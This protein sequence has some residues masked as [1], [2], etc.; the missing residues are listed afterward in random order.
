MLRNTKLILSQAITRIFWECFSKRR[1]TSHRVPILV[2]HRV[3]PELLE[4]E[5]DPLYTLLPEQFEAHLAFLVREGFRTLSLREFAQLARGQS[6]PHERAVVITFDDGLADTYAIAWPL[7]QKYGIKINLFVCTGLVGEPG[8]V[9]MTQNG[10]VV[11]AGPAEQTR[12]IASHLH[13]FPHLWRALTWEELKEMNQ[14][15]VDLGLH[16]HSHRNLA[17][18]SA[19]ELCRE[20][21]A[22]IQ[23]FRQRLGCH[24]DFFA[25]PYG[26]HEPN[27][28]EVA[29]VLKKQGV[30]FIFTTIWGRVRVPSPK[31]IFPRISM[32]QQDSTD[33][34]KLKLC[35]ACDWLGAAE[36]L[37]LKVKGLVRR[38]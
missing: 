11:S 10:Y 1:E 2:Y 28:Q 15:G 20:I 31:T 18:L 19:E 26:G 3:L 16:G 14:G 4:D 27:L 35:G 23:I 6:A 12:R 36:R 8:P 22:G 24:P 30:S 25:L 29:E 13:Q 37:I 7:A 33:V 34:L 21:T 38:R 5:N 32:Y 9:I 17:F